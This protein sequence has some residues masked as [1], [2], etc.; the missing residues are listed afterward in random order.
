[1]FHVHGLGVVVHG[2]IYTGGSVVM[3][4]RFNPE[5]ALHLISKYR[6]NVFMGVPTMY[7]MLLQVSNP[8]RYDLSHMRLFI[9]GSA[10]LSPKTFRE[11]KDTYG[12]E[13]VERYG[14][15]ETVMNISNPYDGLRKPGSVGLPLPGVQVRIVNED[16]VDLVEG[17]VGE[18]L[19]KGSN[20]TEGYWNMSEETENVF[21]DGW[22]RT[23]DLGVRDHDGY[24][25]I[26]GRKKEM[27][28]TSGFKVYPREVEELLSAHK[29]VKEAAVIGVKDELKGE[30]VKAF[31]VPEPGEDITVEEIIAYC[32]SNLAA[33][34][35]PRIIELI[36]DLPR[37][38]S[39]KIAKTA[40]K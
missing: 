17:E 30:I 5:Q 19:V 35:T 18:I 7:V 40:L 25:S 38:A 1:M 8:H 10:P 14:L 13:I 31:I 4:E 15:T 9:S 27:I 22:F 20:V 29:K 33:F 26:A 37:T 23:G 24:V 12:F 28:I 36:Q 34:K 16:G 11:F 2:V 3:M 32:R 6:C 39:G 21:Q